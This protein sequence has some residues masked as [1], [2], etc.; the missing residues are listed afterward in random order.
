VSGGSLCLNLSGGI[1]DDAFISATGG[2]KCF[3][4]G[5]PISPDVLDIITLDTDSHTT[6][7]DTITLGSGQT[8][9]VV[10]SSS[11]LR[12]DV[13]VVFD[14]LVLDT[15]VTGKG[16]LKFFSDGNVRDITTATGSVVNFG[17]VTVE[18]NVG[19]IINSSGTSKTSI[20]NVLVGGSTGDII[21]NK[22]VKN[23]QARSTGEIQA[24]LGSVTNV[25]VTEDIHSV[26]AAID[27]KSITAGG[28]IVDMFAGRDI[29][30]IR[31]D[32][33]DKAVAGR[34]V[35]DVKVT[36]R[37]GEIR[38][39]KSISLVNG[40]SIGTLGGGDG[41]TLTAQVTQIESGAD[42]DHI[43]AKAVS[44]VFAKGSLHVSASG[45]A[46]QIASGAPIV[47]PGT[48]PGGQVIA[49]L[50]TSG[51]ISPNIEVIVGS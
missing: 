17:A 28:A 26:W 13:A 34:N 19:D 2:I 16:T 22:F 20:Q 36:G 10:G 18:G 3:N 51:S 42:I 48:F 33:L 45:Q 25:L 47:I 8:I 14:S 32:E 39:G 27:A 12:A 35:K 5:G 30:I 43:V 49:G 37:I 41:F 7:P 46:G 29:S 38:A 4:V 9:S 1:G 11:T 24:L 50:A 31:A 44:K 23:V 6:D 15:T 21:S 40:G